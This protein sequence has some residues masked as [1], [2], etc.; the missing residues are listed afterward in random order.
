MEYA[1]HAE[2]ISSERIGLLILFC[3]SIYSGLH[4]GLN[5]TKAFLYNPSSFGGILLL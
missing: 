2:I 5:K 4:N 3:L 1:M